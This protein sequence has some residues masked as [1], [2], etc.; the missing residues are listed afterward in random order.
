MAPGMLVMGVKILVFTMIP[1][2]LTINQS[3]GLLGCVATP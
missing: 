3:R 1:C 2:V